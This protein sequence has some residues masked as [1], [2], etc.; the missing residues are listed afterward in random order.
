MMAK[1]PE[2]RFGNLGQVIEA[3]ESFLG[4][5]GAGS[6]AP[7]E[8]QANLLEA[9]VNTFNSAASART[10]VLAVTGDSHR[11]LRAWRSFAYSLD[12]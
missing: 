9:C 11:V 5:A 2:E 1:R 6:F 12:V 3:L 8:D 4:V 10:A 7:R